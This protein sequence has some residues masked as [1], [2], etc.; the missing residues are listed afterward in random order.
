MHAHFISVLS[1]RDK[2][3]LALICCRKHLG[4]ACLEFHTV[5]EVPVELLVPNILFTRL[6]INVLNYIS[7]LLLSHIV[8]T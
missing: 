4:Y 8:T 6:K 1:C 3:R 7:A 5:D 2:T